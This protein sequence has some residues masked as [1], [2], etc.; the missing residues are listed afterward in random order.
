MEI[1]WRCVQSQTVGRYLKLGVI[2]DSI[3]F[4]KI[5]PGF[6]VKACEH[7]FSGSD[8]TYT[9]DTAFVGDISSVEVTFD[10][11]EAMKEP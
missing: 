2:N 8:A 4:I 1:L 5:S 6:K 3:S 10:A 11:K 9:A 7:N